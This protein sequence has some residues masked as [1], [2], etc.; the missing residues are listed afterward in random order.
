[1]ETARVEIGRRDRLV[2]GDLQRSRD[3]EVLSMVVSAE[4]KDLTARR[5]VMAH[6]G[7][8]FADLALF[9]SGLALKWRG[10]SGTKVYESVEGD[11]LFEAAHTGSHVELAFTLQDPSLHESWSVRGKLTLDPG[12]ELTDVSE[13]LNEL[14]MP[15]QPAP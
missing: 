12:E 11:L 1:M 10:W 5:E 6:Y 7:N 13:D 14:L 2:L 8:G 3:G 9:F 15:P 4:L